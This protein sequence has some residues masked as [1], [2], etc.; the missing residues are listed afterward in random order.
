MQLLH[1]QP[2]SV[3]NVDFDP[4]VDL[5]QLRPL[6]EHD[7]STGQ[8]KIPPS[9]Y[10]FFRPAS[11]AADKSSDTRRVFVLGGSTVQGRP[12][13]A[14]TAFSTWLRLRLQ[15]AS[16]EWNYEVVNC[17]GVSYA[18]YRVAKILQ[19]V[20]QHQPDAIVIYTGHNEFLEDRTY[21]TVRDG[22]WPTRLA[23]RLTAN[24][25]TVGWLKRQVSADLA[26]PVMASEVDAKLD[27]VGGLESYQRDPNWRRAIERH[28]QSKLSEMVDATSQAGVPLVLCTP[29]SDIV[30]TPPIKTQLKPGFNKEQRE[31]FQ[32]M[33]D[34][35]SDNTAGASDRMAAANECLAMDDQHCGAHYILGRLLYQSNE[36]LSARTH[37]V[38]ARDWDV[39]P[40]RATT[41]IIGTVR[42]AAESYDVLYVDSEALFDQ[43]GP[44]GQSLPDKI[45]DPSRFT[46]HLHPTIAAHQL[47][48]KEI[49]SR[50]ADKHWRPSVKDPES[51]Y[52]RLA[53]QHLESLD[54]SYYARGKQRLEGLHRWATGRAGQ[55]GTKNETQ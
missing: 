53:Q 28:F 34:I 12:Y 44:T 1:H 15:A 6:F 37:L 31:D 35:A 36:I 52:Q 43:R 5:H 27:H 22:S 10:N 45:P 41:A 17:G 33:L 7:E 8:W 21:A 30:D 11:F 29:A 55:L 24:L 14:E 42:Q 4:Y 3:E 50:L 26:K 38:A 16:P 47:L 2:A 49:A 19:E 39:C 20:L 46:D 54:E 13:S 23:N 48:A 18:S 25:K 40:L 9:R 51:A 32:A